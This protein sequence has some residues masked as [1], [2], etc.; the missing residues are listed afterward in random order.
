MEKLASS[1]D[2]YFDRQFAGR[3]ENGKSRIE[4]TD[5]V[6]ETYLNGNP[7]SRGK[8]KTTAAE[9]DAAFW[10]SA[11]LDDLP[12]DAWRTET[13]VLA[14]ARYLSQ[15]RVSNTV[16][17]KQVAAQ[18]PDVLHRAV[19]YSG[20]VLRPESLRRAE[21]EEVA[22]THPDIVELCRMLAIFEE[23]R[24]TLT[25]EVEQCKTQLKDLKSLE[26]LLL[27]SVFAFDLTVPQRFGVQATVV[28]V[29]H[30]P[31]YLWDAVNDL[32]I[33]SL[34]RSDA[35]SL[36]LNEARVAALIGP[37]LKGLLFDD[38]DRQVETK[39]LFGQ[40]GELLTAQIALNDFCKRSADAFS[41]DDAIRFAR[42]GGVLELEL[43]DPARHSS[44]ENDGRKLE[45]LHVYWVY[46]AM[47]AFVASG[48]ATQTIGRPENH[49][50]NRFAWLNALSCRLRLTEVYGVG[51]SVSIGSGGSVNVFRASLALELMSAFFRQDFLEPFVRHRAVLG[52][53]TDALRKLAF[54]GL[55][56]GLGNRFP[57]TWS[58]RAA[59]V[60]N[61]TGWTV[62]DEHPQGSASEAAAV[63]DHWT[64]DVCSIS[65][66]LNAGDTVRVPELLERPVLQFGGIFV[67][68]PWVVGLQNNTTAAINNLR[69]IG[70]LRGEVRDETARIEQRLG[71]QFEARGFRVMANWNP[72]KPLADDERWAGEV[73][74]ICARDGI[75]L[76]LEVKSTYLRRS[77]KDA[78]RHRTSTLRK[79]GQQV[80]RKI[81]AVQRTLVA[82]PAQF[83]LL[84]LG[85][86]GRPPTLHG[87]IVDTS[88]ECD[89]EHF[90]GFLKLS[91][92]EV[93][94]ALRDD[95]HLL[96]DPGGLSTGGLD[97]TGMDDA[98]YV[99][100]TLYPDGF[101]AA[102]FVEVIE[103]GAVWTCAVTA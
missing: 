88:I 41:Y 78:W 82:E 16:L 28:S 90:S 37:L 11:F 65:A 62:C 97:Q 48:L 98:A 91:V 71:Q 20:L 10:V 60:R 5:F 73:D 1:I 17:L 13:M 30:D 3:I 86:A 93:L 67:Q 12:T 74:L 40:F 72:S 56:Q 7:A 59:K 70:S 100:K 55:V 39:V 43:I 26:L 85:V 58:D 77:T 22:N 31:Q 36:K 103:G 79:A 34:A 84:R 44:W 81:E 75:V 83:A 9:R 69:R 80:R 19:R 33:W 87:W 45:R 8:H 95:S 89:H 49:E 66:Q 27:A 96:D 21:L 57:L 2:D 63:L 64:Y 25:A 24:R 14:L 23:E 42:V 35:A 52:E 99:K 15:E 92:E 46:R 68:L 50:A 94:I 51:D 76:V 32:L 29:P 18:A 47:D 61:I 38:P 53:T 6:C 102:R 101:D 54:E 4:A